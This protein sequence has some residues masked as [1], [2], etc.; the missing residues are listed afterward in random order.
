MKSKAYLPLIAS[1]LTIG[2][3]GCSK[4]L[5]EGYIDPASGAFETASDTSGR[6]DLRGAIPGQ[7]IVKFKDNA[8]QAVKLTRQRSAVELMSLNPTLQ[9][10]LNSVGAQKMVPLIPDY[11]EHHERRHKYGLDRWMII[12]FDQSKTVPQAL[13]MFEAL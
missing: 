11:P 5:T 1:L 2:A 13:Q 12:Y 7:L 9:S 10:V 4:Q 8:F 6:Q 3:A